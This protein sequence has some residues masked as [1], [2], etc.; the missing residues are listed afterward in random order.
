MIN[1]YFSYDDLFNSLILGGIILL[2]L[3]ALFLILFPLFRGIYVFKNFKKVYYKKINKIVLDN[4]YLLINELTLKDHAGVICSIDHLIFG[5]KYI[6]VI[7]DRFY[8]GAISG[9]IDDNVWFFYGKKGVKEEFENPMY[10]NMKRIEK[11]SAVTQYDKS[12]FVSIVLINDN[13]FVK[14]LKELNSGDNSFILPVSKLRRFLKK[15]EKR[16]I[17]NLDQKE[18]E[19]AVLD[20][21]EFKG[22]NVDE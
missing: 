9:G 16:N 12:Y 19:K 2:A 7:K 5:Y 17:P 11:L 8:R 15:I 22:K 13:A 4:D 21:A 3:L 18:L 10:N 20:I 14:N 1:I 6:Y